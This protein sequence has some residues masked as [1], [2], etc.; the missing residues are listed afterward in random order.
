MLQASLVL[1]CKQYRLV[2]ST[3]MSE[4]NRIYYVR[5]PFYFKMTLLLA[6]VSVFLFSQLSFHDVK[7]ALNWT[8]QI[9]DDHA[10]WWDGSLCPCNDTRCIRQRSFPSDM[11]GVG[12]SCGR[13]AW[14][15]G[16]GQR[17]IT[18]S[19]FG[20]LTKYWNGLGDIL[21][22][23]KQLYPGWNVWLYTIPSGRESILCPLMHA[24]PHLYICDVTNLPPPLG[25]VTEVNPSMWRFLAMGDDML[26]AMAVR[27]TD[28]K[29]TERESC[30]VAEWLTCNTSFHV[31]RDHPFH[32][33]PVLAGLWGAR[34]DLEGRNGS[35]LSP[36]AFRAL[37]DAMRTRGKKPHSREQDQRV[38]GVH[39]HQPTTASE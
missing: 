8:R 3:S 6:A 38:L 24:H 27:D 26:S 13:R 31:M 15:A 22:T 1:H 25:N 5:A 23:T 12:G 35:A 34:W 39:K 10:P 7:T 9:H 20:N 21:V 11:E 30:A 36:G 33:S 29:I 17:V 37:R 14:A 28:S 4:N 2:H 16:G 18:Y 19:L 32:A